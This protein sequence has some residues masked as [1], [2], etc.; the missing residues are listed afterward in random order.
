MSFAFNEKNQKYFEKLLNRY[1]KK[2]GLTLPC[3]WMVQYQ[4]GYISQEAM[5]YIG[6]LLELSPMDIYS[7][8][9]FYTMFNLK[10]I[11]KYHIAVCKTLSCMLN[12]S[13]SLLAHL[14]KK[15]KISSGESTEDGIFTLSEVECLGNCQGAPCISLNDEYF[16][17]LTID[18]IDN[19]IDGLKK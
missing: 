17:N 2:E 19:I 3:L 10:P 4:E 5:I 8:A 9:S 11:G 7:I 18:E 12:G 16:S 6:D 15:L 1:P 13:E 14:E